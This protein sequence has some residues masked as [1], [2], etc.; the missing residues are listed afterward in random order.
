MAVAT[1][2][3]IRPCGQDDLA[4]VAALLADDELG[5]GRELS[6]DDISA[7]EA[8]F[9]EIEPD[10][11]NTVFVAEADGRV[12]GCYQL[13]IIPNLSF[14]GGRRALIEGVRVAENMRG[15]GLGEQMMIHAIAT[16]REQNCRIV[17]LTS[18]RQRP[19]AIRFYEGLGFEPSHVGFK[20]YL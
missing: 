2:N 20:L 19:G 3:L 16:A 10:P 12:V 11:R 7:Y 4:Q 17:Q 15:K 18:N 8:A 14:E 9:R 6:T 13:T 5:A 1:E